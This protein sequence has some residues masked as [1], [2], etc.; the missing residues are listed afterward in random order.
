MP[1]RPWWAG[2]QN[3]DLVRKCCTTDLSHSGEERSMRLHPA[4]FSWPSTSSRGHSQAL[5]TASHWSHKKPEKMLR[6]HLQPV[7]HKG[8]AGPSG[9]LMTKDREKKSPR[10]TKVSFFSAVAGKICSWNAQV[11]ASGSRVG[12]SK[13]TWNLSSRE[14]KFNSEITRCCYSI[15]ST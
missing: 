5:L 1:K 12:V 8:I 7:E 9:D 2:R 4:L 6:W 10:A 15:Y 11:H 13:E 14:R 3:T